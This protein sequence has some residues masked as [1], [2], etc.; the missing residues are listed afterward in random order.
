MTIFE[1]ARDAL[2][3]RREPDHDLTLLEARLWLWK[4]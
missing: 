1:A 3:T 4:S 2:V